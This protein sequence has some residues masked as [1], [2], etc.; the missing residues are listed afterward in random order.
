MRSIMLTIMLVCF[1]GAVTAMDKNDIKSMHKSGVDASVIIKMAN[2]S[3][4]TITVSDAAEFRKSGVPENILSILTVHDAGT[5]VSR[6][7]TI[8]QILTTVT[9]TPECN[10]VVSNMGMVGFYVVVA[11]DRKEVVISDS[12]GGYYVETGKNLVLS[13]PP[14]EYKVR[15]QGREDK[16]SARVKRGEVTR[17]NIEVKSG[18][19]YGCVYRDGD[20]KDSGYIYEKPRPVFITQAP[21][22][23]VV[24][25]E[26]TVTQAP[27]VV[28]YREEPV[29]VVRQPVYSCP[30]PRTSWYF[31]FDF[32][33][34]SGHRD[35]RH[36][37]HGHH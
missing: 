5:A 34:R 19:V 29:Y 18:T 12:I 33:S 11:H 14:V 3:N 31:N 27:P 23:Q 35:Y 28:I 26:R 36:G 20:E 4:I 25:V 13:F 21:E 17:V 6:E 32:D 7:Q 10:F 1:C 30:P 15:W 24:V 9:Y 22:P 8:P 2:D 16:L 37:G